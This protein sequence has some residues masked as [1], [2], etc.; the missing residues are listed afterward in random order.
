[1]GAS[2]NI[3]RVIDDFKSF[4]ILLKRKI[5][6]NTCYIWKKFLTV[7]KFIVHDISHQTKNGI[8]NELIFFLIGKG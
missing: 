4:N 7:S 8:L 1:M 6:T 2:V 3:S 5:M